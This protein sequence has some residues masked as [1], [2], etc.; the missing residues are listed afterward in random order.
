[1]IV[2]WLPLTTRMTSSSAS[3]AQPRSCATGPNKAEARRRTCI[4]ERQETY[5]PP[6]RPDLLGN[7]ER[8]HP[9]GRIAC[10]EVRAVRLYLP[11]GSEIFRRHGFDSQRRSPLEIDAFALKAVH[12]NI[13]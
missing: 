11:H 9:A 6:C 1:M 7:L 3:P 12:R 2:V 8:R 10:N 4:D 13:S 5:L